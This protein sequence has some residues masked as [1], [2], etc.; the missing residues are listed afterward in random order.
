MKGKRFFC[1]LLILLMIFSLA[2]DKTS[3]ETTVYFT[4]VNDQLLPDLSDETMPF[5][6]G[7][8]L[9]VPSAVI[10]GTDLGLFYSRSRDKS[11]AVVYRQGSAL[12][13]NFSAG[14]II[15]QNDHQYSGSAIVRGDVVFLPLALLAQFFSLDYSYTRVTYGYLVRVKSDTVV[16]SDAKF[17]EAATMS[18]E[19][20]Y[21]E[22]IK[23][24]N[25]AGNPG[26]TPDTD[27]SNDRSHVYLALRVTDAS[28]TGEL[29]DALTGES[30]SATFLFA[31]ESISSFGDL[32]R[33]IIVSGNTAALRIDASGGSS[34]TISA[35]ERA[36][37][38]LWT[39]C[40][41]KTRLVSLYGAS[42]ETL[43]AVRAAG[44]CP[45][46]FDL[47][48]STDMPST[49]LAANNILRQARSGS[50][51]VYL[52]TDTA[53]QESWSLLLSRLHASSRSTA[54]LN[55]IAAANEA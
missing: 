34:R 50:C 48:Y 2:P 21:N 16:L 19:Q 53:V 51:A 35:I 6:S 43:R 13:F 52:G 1:L 15:D 12:T 20:R 36:N 7:G 37:S 55:E 31:E 41:E 27:T 40:N 39:A 45:I 10:T 42:D 44:Y 9:Y 14:T 11:T 49:A 18:M 5:W 8:Q 23:S 33:R 3:A 28:V 24:H 17:I 54:A 47:D 32:L 38:A 25:E 29:L 46:L 22:Y 30:A 4:A 26:D